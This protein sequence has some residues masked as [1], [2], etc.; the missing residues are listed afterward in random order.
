M[1]LLPEVAKANKAR[2]LRRVKEQ[3]LKTEAE[4]ALSQQA[5]GIAR[6]QVG[7]V[8]NLAGSEASIGRSIASRAMGSRLPSTL[9][10]MEQALRRLTP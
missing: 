2:L 4:I 3:I 1:V 6:Q 9:K 5:L 8:I 10:Q 7:Q